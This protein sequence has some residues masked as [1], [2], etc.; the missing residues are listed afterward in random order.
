M[1]IHPL[2]NSLPDAVRK[3]VSEASHLKSYRKGEVVLAMNEHMTHAFCVASG[4]I[5]IVSAGSA[6]VDL[7]TGFLKPDEIF[8]G[9]SL[10][11]GDAE[12][13]DVRLVAALPTSAYLVPRSHLRRLCEQYPIV[14]LRLIDA[15]LEKNRMLRRQIRRVATLSAEQIVARA[16]YDLTQPGPE[17]SRAFDKRIPQSVIASYVGLSRPV[18]NRV[19]KEMEGRGLL[20]RSEDGIV[21]SHEIGAS[22]D[23]GS[24]EDGL[25]AGAGRDTEYLAPDFDLS[26][27]PQ[28]DTAPGAFP[29]EHTQDNLPTR[30]GRLEED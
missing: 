11:S 17:G 13:A 9:S 19:F 6:D 18:V 12:P 26:A 21:L 1:Y 20:Q 5:R 14:G 30:R 23:F 7:T 24:L 16:L 25:A 27:K 3:F 28:A 10:A 8:I 22:T 15:T 2:L 4:L 29:Q